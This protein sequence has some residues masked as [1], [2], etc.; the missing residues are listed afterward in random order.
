MTAFE[1]SRVARW[2]FVDPDGRSQMD[3][4]LPLKADQGIFWAGL[5]NVGPTHASPMTHVIVE[6]FN[7][8]EREGTPPFAIWL[9][10]NPCGRK[11]L[12]IRQLWPFF[13]NPLAIDN[14]SPNCPDFVF[15]L[16]V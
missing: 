9:M 16:L 15:S 11:P 10:I 14:I 12:Q 7:P 13:A 4:I 5:T 2:F 1:V 8:S 6:L 3:V